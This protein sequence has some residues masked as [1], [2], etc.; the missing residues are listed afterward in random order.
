MIACIKSSPLWRS[1]VQLT[2]SANMRAHLLGNPTGDQVPK[3]QLQLG[4]GL[5]QQDNYG[6]VDISSIS[7]CVA[8][9]NEL[10]QRVLPNHEH[11]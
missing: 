4:H 8:S 3:Q 9:D 1:V 7:Q 10:M 2:L 6:D 5:V 11:Q